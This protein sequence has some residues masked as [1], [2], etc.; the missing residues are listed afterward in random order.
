M[1]KSGAASTQ[2]AAN[3]G[4]NESTAAGGQEKSIKRIWWS[5]G[6]DETPLEGASRHYVDLNV[7]VETENYADGEAVELI[8]AN[9]DGSDLFEGKSDFAVHVKVGPEGIGKAMNVFG[10]KTVMLGQLG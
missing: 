3:E 1:A 8:L 10:G 6:D 4:G 9:D 2:L 7:H 5:Y